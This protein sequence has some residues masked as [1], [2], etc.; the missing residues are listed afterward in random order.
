M[1]TTNET[2]PEWISDVLATRGDSSP[3][4]VSLAR[5][6]EE[7]DTV[8]PALRRIAASFLESRYLNGRPRSRA[9]DPETSTA[10]EDLARSR[11]ARPGGTVH[12][13]LEAYASV[14]RYPEAHPGGCTSREIEFVS[15]TRAAH[16]RTS[17]LLRDGLLEVSST[18][19][20]NES[21]SSEPRDLVRKGGRVLH[22]TRAGRDELARLDA[23]A[24][25]RREREE[26]I[27]ARRRAREERREAKAVR[28][29]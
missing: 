3:T 19:V 13:I 5:M 4:V 17:E 2:L 7:D 15:R 27:A 9:T 23:A 18:W 16:K 26:A 6:L 24:K 14:S 10:G 1:T 25:R 20:L 21:G 29:A 12:R 8:P 28:S 22:I 11:V